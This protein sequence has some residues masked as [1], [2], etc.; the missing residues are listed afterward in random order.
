MMTETVQVKE[1]NELKNTQWLA[2]RLRISKS[3]LEKWRSLG[4]PVLPP[5]IHIGSMIR[6]DENEVE[7]WL[8]KQREA[9]VNPNPKTIAITSEG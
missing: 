5:A 1:T 6:Y 8:L 7:E 3:T 2:E 9:F 4:F